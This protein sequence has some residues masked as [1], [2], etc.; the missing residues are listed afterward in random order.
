[1]DR[2]VE[3]RVCCCRSDEVLSLCDLVNICRFTSASPWWAQLYSRKQTT[4]EKFAWE[5]EAFTGYLLHHLES[6]FVLYAAA[7]L[8]FLGRFL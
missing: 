2:F 1:M 5:L 7:P 8:G 3:Q 4:H 6:N